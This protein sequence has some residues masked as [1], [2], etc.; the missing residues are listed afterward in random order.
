[1][2][3]LRDIKKRLKAVANIQQITK[4]MELVAASRLH[5]AQEKALGS[6]VYSERLRE[7]LGNIVHVNKNHPYFVKRPV[8]R[9]GVII[10]TSDKGLCGSYNNALF[11]AADPFLSTISTPE[12]VVLGRKGI[13]HY[14]SRKWKIRETVVGWG[15]KISREEIENLSH[16][17]MNAFLHEELDEVWIIYTRYINLFTRKVVIEKM[18][19]IDPAPKKEPFDL[20]YIFEPGTEEIY[21]DLIPR[22]FINE[23]KMAITQA[24]ASELAA[25][26]CSMR[27]AIKNADEMKEKL[28]LTRNKIRQAG[29]T[30]EM[31]EIASGAEG[32]K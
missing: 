22:Y 16:L 9:T 23:F 15:G 26:T 21:D 12:L 8:N 11:R 27:Q 28:T 4:A 29:I 17:L 19:P 3:S 10:I 2:A 7:I 18:L 1:M 14:K 6:V 25:R 13:D 31:A 24:Y 5:K 20:D 32:L 30:A